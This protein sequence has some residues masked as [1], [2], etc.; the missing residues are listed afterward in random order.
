M[1]VP[2]AGGEEESFFHSTRKKG[3]GDGA[4]GERG[5]GRVQRRGERAWKRLGSV[6]SGVPEWYSLQLLLD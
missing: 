4:T 3:R 6:M 5:K 1:A 2:A